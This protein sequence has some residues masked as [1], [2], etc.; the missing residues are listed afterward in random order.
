MVFITKYCSIWSGKVGRNCW[1]VHSA[2]NMKSAKHAG[3]LF[4]TNTPWTVARKCNSVCIN[5]K[6]ELLA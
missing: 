3:E 1:K 6:F 5:Q 4:A 2:E